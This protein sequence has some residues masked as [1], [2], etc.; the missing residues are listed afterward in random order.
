MLGRPAGW[1]RDPAPRDPSAP[2]TRRFWDGTSWTASTR[3]ASRQE[4]RA[5]REEAVAVRLARLRELV[6]RAD[7]GDEEAQRQLITAAPARSARRTTADGQVLAGWWARVAASLLDG[8]LVTVLGCVVGWRYVQDI[9]EGYRQFLGASVHASEAGAPVP[10]PRTLLDAVAGPL[11]ATSLIIALVGLAFEVGFLR[12]CQ[13]TPGK[14]ALGLQVRPCDQ[15]GP[16]CWRAALLRWAGKGGAGLL[17][18][19]PFGVVVYALYALL[20]YLWPLGDHHRQALHDKVA[21]TYV[22]RRA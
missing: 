15:P 19:L 8:L 17:R 13:A 11:L 5:W 20:D 21:R 10:D 4:R 6:A 18:F 9:G 3:T 16:L 22:V 7:A 2:D 14:L 12:S 1:Y